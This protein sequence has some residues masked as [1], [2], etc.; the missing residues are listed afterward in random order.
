MLLGWSRRPAYSFG[1]APF[2]VIFSMNLFLWFKPDWFYLQFLLVAVVFAAK[3]R[4]RRS[5]NGRRV[6]ACNPSAFALGLV[7]LGRLI[8]GATDVTWGQEIATTLNRPPQI[9]LFIF[10]IG[11][12]GQLLFGV[13]TMTMSAVV[14][15]YAFG[16]GYYALH[17]TYYFVDSYVPISVFLGMHLLFTDPSTS[18]RTE[19]GRVI[20]GA[21]YA[22]SVVALYAA[23]GRLAMPTFYDKLMAV[24]LMNLTLKGI[25]RLTESRWAALIDPARLAPRLAGR[26]RYLA[27][28]GL[29]AGVFVVMSAAQAVG[30]T[31]RGQWVPFWLQACRDARPFA[32]RTAASLTST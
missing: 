27:Y 22:L 11:L 4:I 31:H 20:F 8:G 26:S 6:H 32:C 10:L 19:L 15:M 2:P 14:A 25:D 30:D 18:P 3:V 13:T 12:P 24:P 16:L 1:F 5:K 28:A 23:L 29:W 17:G 9:Y 7:S 21:L